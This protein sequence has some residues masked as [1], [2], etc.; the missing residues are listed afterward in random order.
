MATRAAHVAL[1][2]PRLLDE[3]TAAAYLGISK[4]NFRARWENKELPQPHKL[5]ARLLWDRHL[6]DRYVD[7]LSGLGSASDSWGDL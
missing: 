5:G 7:A 4:T 1:P 6:L 2:V 3:P